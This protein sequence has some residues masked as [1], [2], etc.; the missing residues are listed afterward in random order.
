MH[1]THHKLLKLP[2]VHH[3]DY[4]LR[5]ICNVKA[6]III[7]LQASFFMNYVVVDNLLYALTGLTTHILLF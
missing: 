3:I 4:V 5:D 2:Q 6:H 7:S 1:N